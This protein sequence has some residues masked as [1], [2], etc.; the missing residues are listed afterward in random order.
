MEDDK[1]MELIKLQNRPR[2]HVGIE[3]LIPTVQFGNKKYSIN[4]SDSI[5]SLTPE[6][7]VDMMYM[8]SECIKK[9]KVK[10]GLDLKQPQQDTK[11]FVKATSLKG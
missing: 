9:Q 2:V 5:E 8:A 10:D 6:K 4:I 7:L 11:G 1:V 3:E